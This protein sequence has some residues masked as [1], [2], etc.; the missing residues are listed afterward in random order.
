MQ[1]NNIIDL[2][3]VGKYEKALLAWNK[4]LQRI[5]KLECYK[6]SD[7]HFNSLYGTID[8]ILN[9]DPFIKSTANKRI[10]LVKSY[11]YQIDPILE[12]FV[13]YN[14]NTL[15][16]ILYGVI[17]YNKCLVYI[18]QT[19]S[20]YK[21][22]IIPPY[23]YYVNN[24]EI[25][26]L[27]DEEYDLNTLLY[28]GEELFDIGMLG[29]SIVSYSIAKEHNFSLWYNNNIYLNGFIHSSISSELAAT[30]NDIETINSIS[31]K[32][33]D[34]VS[35]LSHTS[36]VLNTPE[37]IEI[38]HKD[39]VNTNVGASYKLYVDQIKR[40]I[41]DIILARSTQEN[42]TTYASEKIRYLSTLDIQFTDAK[43]LEYIVNNIIKK[44]Y[45]NIDRSL[46]FKIL[47]ALD[48]DELSIVQVLNGLKN[49]DAT[50]ANGAP[51]MIDS[52]WLSD[53]CRIPLKNKGLI[54]LSSSNQSAIG[55]SLVTS[56]SS[57]SSS[58]TSLEFTDV[59]DGGVIP[60]VP[61]SNTALNGAQIASLLQILANIASGVLTKESA[62]ALISASFPSITIDIVH[63]IV[64]PIKIVP[65]YQ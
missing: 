39:I 42:D 61:V 34:H 62:I 44:I 4:N 56:T 65:S 46:S 50:D 23:K 2:L 52:K 20:N 53:T 47:T 43:Q 63:N 48:E 54:K 37:G 16:N 41:E 55:G 45:G 28:F 8:F 19:I 59:E 38:T 57:T 60:D 64:D 12:Q 26:F 24:G 40:E 22:H 21:L 1:Y 31:D 9:K 6:W 11:D 29:A 33:V 7:S 49:L 18:E 15:Y 3:L 58:D 14:L 5:M 25:I 17:F 10:F 36:G 27:N 51:L 35:N 13:S 32:V 30:V